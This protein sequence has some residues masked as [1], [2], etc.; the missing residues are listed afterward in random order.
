MFFESARDWGR[1]PSS[2][3]DDRKPRS[4]GKYNTK[5]SLCGGWHEHHLY[6]GCGFLKS[7]KD[8]CRRGEGET[9]VGN[10]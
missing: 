7:W 8:S 3:R 5:T 9:N 6:L 10:W 2:A 4:V 1:E